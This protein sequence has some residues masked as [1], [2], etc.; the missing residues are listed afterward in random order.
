MR[1]RRHLA[2]VCCLGFAIPAG[3]AQPASHCPPTAT[4]AVDL[5]VTRS[6][7]LAGTPI[8]IVAFGSS[9]T[10]GAGATDSAHSYPAIL[11]AELSRHLATAHVSVINRGIGGEDAFEQLARIGRDAIAPRPQLVIWQV[12]AN[13]VLRDLDPEAFRVNVVAGIRRIRESGADVILMDNQR[14][15]RIVTAP[16][17][18]AIEQGLEQAAQATATPVFSRGALMDAWRT[19]GQDHT[20]FLAADALHHND[21]GYRCVAEALTRT[22]M[23]ALRRE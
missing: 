2:L 3:W 21:L 7:L 17:R 6:A 19:Q 10:Q 20:R 9:S 16:R 11:Q 18:R 15:E 4:P 23:T 22:I 14:A 5:P 1:F 13:A 8:V 12:G